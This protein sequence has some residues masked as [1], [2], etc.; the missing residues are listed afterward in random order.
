[1]WDR[2]CASIIIMIWVW[3]ICFRPALPHA[4]LSVAWAL[5]PALG[6][7]A[8]VSGHVTLADSRDPAVRKKLD[9]SGVVVSL[10]PLNG[11]AAMRVSNKHARIIQKNKTFTP[12]LIAIQT[13]TT[14]D[15]PN[16][17]PIFHNA[18]SSYDG[19]IFDVGLY[20]PGSNRSV[21]FTRPG[22]VRVFCNIH[23]AMSAVIVVLPTP[24]FD[25]TD[26]GGYFEIPNVPPG[27]YDLH[28][29]HERS[30]QA[31][32][33]A[34]RHRVAV[35]DAPV[36]LPTISISESGYLAIPHK[37]KYGRDYPPEPDDHSIY[38]AVKK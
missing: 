28:V 18:F 33:A 13:G 24:Y 15:M 36:T 7:A 21:Q 16:L 1:M 32:L 34:L 27:D 12:H 35:S 30:T 31:T 20:P 29:F 38:P 6:V 17:D 19:Q 3:R 23:A 2:A 8:T 4:L 22:V 11:A 25:A 9:Y 37:N 5:L 26:A 10:R 14:V